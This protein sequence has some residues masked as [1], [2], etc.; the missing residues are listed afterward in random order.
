MEVAN[1]KG[2][3]KCLDQL[4]QMFYNIAVDGSSSCFP[5]EEDYGI[6]E[7]DEDDGQDG[8]PM[9]TNTRK[10]A[11]STATTTTSQIKKTKSTMVK[12]MKEL[13]ESMKSNN[14]TQ[15]LLN[16]DQIAESMKKCQ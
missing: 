3:P 7:D 1:K 5:G 9:S 6:E 8:S 2:A 16:G 13:M 14:S 4:E 12:V 15:K 10:R 11:S